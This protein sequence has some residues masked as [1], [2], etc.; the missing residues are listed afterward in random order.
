MSDDAS[1]TIAII[2]DTHYWAR[3]EPVYTSEGALQLQPWS[4]Q[5]L[6]TLLADVQAAQAELILH[7]GD[8]VCGGGGYAMSENEFEE[9]LDLMYRCLHDI[10]VPVYALPGNHDVRPSSGDLGKFYALW[11]YEP[12]IGKTIDLPQA[13][14]ILLNT[15]GHTPEQIAVAPDSDP[16][17]GFVADA[18]LERLDEALATLDKRPA[19][20]FTHQL[21]MPW[22]N[23]KPWRDFYGV[24][25][26]A[27]VLTVIERR[28]GVSA[29]IQGHAHRLD[30]QEL[31]LGGRPCVAAVMPATIEYPVGWMKLHLSAT[32][33]C[34]QLRRLPLAEISAYAEES[35]G[36]QSWRHGK[37]T[38]WDYQFAL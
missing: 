38:W 7:L 6:A 12:G 1:T 15:M 5:I 10:G 14:L 22:S 27:Q 9:T 37:S 18:E 13:R 16:V 24:R 30:I 34:L 17:Y 19:L 33:G 25:N 8:Q 31:V 4:E 35:G 20:I 2:T 21:L 11:Q 23:G 36:G 29:I 32:Q 3:S 28:G 26:A